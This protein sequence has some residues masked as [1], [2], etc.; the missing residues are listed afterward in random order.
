[1]N[2]RFF[3]CLLLLVS[4]L[5]CSPYEP[6]KEDLGT[7]PSSDE[8]T[9]TLDVNPESDNIYTFQSTHPA[10]FVSVWDLGN[11]VKTQGQQVEGIYP[12]KGNYEIALTIVTAAGEATT[13]FSVDIDED[14]YSLLDRKDYNN[15]TGGVDYENGK[16]WVINKSVVG[17]LG[18]GPGDADSP[19]WWG[20]ALDDDRSGCGLYTDVYTF[21]IFGFG[22]EHFTDGRV[23]VNAGYSSDFPGAEDFYPEG[24]EDPA[25]MFAP[26][27]GYAGGWSIEDR[28]D[29]KYLVLNS[30][31][32]KAWIGF[33]VRS[34]RE[35]KVHELTE[36]QLSISSLAE[37]GNRWFHI[38]KP[39]E[40][41]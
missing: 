35:Y 21:N 2:I 14:D 31:N 5:S 19:I 7:P 6:S 27:D 20:I 17:H 18:I 24:S 25:E 9:F 33:Y 13:T 32:D 3:S 8:V 40:A 28:A 38:L 4:I 15:L 26:Y 39:V 41:E 22:Y 10:A 37:D 16:Q 23:Y 36:D 12:L 29:G 1:M 34:N 30:S 11:G